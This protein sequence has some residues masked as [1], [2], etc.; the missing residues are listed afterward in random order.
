MIGISERGI[1]SC[2]GQVHLKA[3]AALLLFLGGIALAVSA[4]EPGK[5]APIRLPIPTPSLTDVPLTLTIVLKRTDQKDFDGFLRSIQTP[6]SPAY[7]QYLSPEE[8]A[9]RF[10]PSVR[11]YGDV[12]QWLRGE[13]FTV[14]EGSANRLTLTATGTRAQAERALQIHL[15]DHKIGGQTFYANDREPT[16][17]GEIAHRVQ[18]VIGL[19]NQARP[20]PVYADELVFGGCLYYAGD[21]AY[22]DPRYHNCDHNCDRLYFKLR[23]RYLR[24]CLLSKGLFPNRGGNGPGGGNPSSSSTSSGL[25][26][27]VDQAPAPAWLGAD[28]TGQTIGLLEFDSFNFNDISDYLAYVG[29]PPTEIDRLSQVHI[30]GGAV[31]GPDEAEVLLDIVAVMTN[32]RGA[33]VVVYDA[34]FAG[35]RASFQTLFNKMITDGVSVISNSWVYC[36]D[37]A[38]LADVQSIDSVLGSAAAAGITVLNSTGDFGSTCVNGSANTIS[39]PADSPNATAVGGTSLSEG[40]GST[41][42]SEIFWNGQRRTPPSGPGG[43]GVSRFFNRPG[44]QNGFSTSPMR[45]IPDVALNADP[46]NGTEICQADAGGCPTGAQ[47]G[48]TSLAAPL[49]AAFVAILN[50]AQGQN[51]G[52]LNPLLYPLGNTN[53]FHSAASMGSDFA[54]VGLG[55]PNLNLIHR[56]LAGKIPGPVSASVSE[57]VANPNGALADGSAQAFVV[58]RLRDADG[59]TVSGKTVTLA[60]N[61][62][63][64]A[65][66]TPGS[67]ISNVAN[68]AV[69]FSV[70]DTTPEIVTFTATDMTDGVALQ[71]QVDVAFVALPAAAGGITA[72]PNTV[73]ADGSTTTTITVTLQDAKGGPA[74]D[75]VVNLSQGDGGSVISTTTATTDAMGK[76]QFTAVSSKAETVTYT[77]VDVTDQ[78]LP[79]PGNAMV[80]FV[81]PSG[82]CSGRNSF[83]FGTAAPGYAVTTF[84]GNFPIDCFSGLGPIGIAFSP[85]NNLLVIDTNNSTLYSFG[86]KGGTASPV[87]SLGFVIPSNGRLAGLTFGRDGRLYATGGGGVFELD[88]ATGAVVRTV[89][90]LNADG[91]GLAVDPISGD[92]FVA[93]PFDG[94]KRILNYSSNTA[95]LVP[96]ASGDF[97]GF[98]F[99]VDGTIYGASGGGAVAR[100]TGTNA[101]TPGVVTILTFLNSP[102]GIG[103]EPNPADASKPFLYVNRNDGIITRIDTSKLPATPPN[104]CGSPCT[105]I[106]TGGSRG[107]FVTVGN[108]RCLYA[109]QSERVIK[110]T[111]ADGTC[112]FAPVSQE[113]RLILTPLTINPPPAQG[114]AVT[115]VASLENVTGAADVPVTLFASGANAL[116]RFVRSD[117][118]GKATFTYTGKFAGADEVSAV[119][120]MGSSQLFSNTANVTWTSGK[121][122]TFLTLNQSLGTGAPNKSIKL[123]ANLVDVSSSPPAP[124]PNATV[125]LHLAGQSC[126]GVT[127]ANGNVV[128]SVTPTVAAGR[129]DLTADFAGTSQFLASSNKKGFDLIAALPH[130]LLNI[131]TRMRV[132]TGDKAL[133]GG[134]IIT[135][136]ESKKV[137]IRGIGPSLSGFGL[138]D[139]LNDPI[140]ELHP[141]N[142]PT[143]TNDN[144]KDSQRA[145]IEASGLAPGDER[146]SAIIATLPP[147]NH[148]AILTG[149]GGSIG[150]GLVEV[151]DLSQP[152][153]ARLANISSRGF[154]DTGDNIMIAGFIAG[155]GTGTLVQV[156]VRGIGPSLTTAGVPDALQDPMLELHDGNGATLAMNDDWKETQ[157]ADIE[158]TQIPPA[159]NRESAILSPLAPGNYTAILRGKNNATGNALVEVYNLP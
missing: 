135:G 105:D 6:G 60:G 48:G 131:S 7:R 153:D 134:F 142:G 147:G 22:H 50:Q 36:E 46:A 120:D 56:A 82:F 17:P 55:S 67:G 30:N 129:Y 42:L 109:T 39:V 38:S 41:Y 49:W 140:L 103:V 43:F 58:V 146:E 104:P 31:L 77:A 123:K 85:D 141:A 21:A 95:T 14:I 54:H 101:V 3:G 86:Q 89:V 45:S 130:Q 37:Q 138:Q 1:R 79:V 87:T 47:Y 127:D 72:S 26:S 126:S 132:L 136:S 10:G 28:G 69:V 137:I 119:A 57:V 157:Q 143:V 20:A 29:L 112:G 152:A 8:Q 80:T 27:L 61:S 71:T 13:G 154:V 59:H 53:A 19:S 81:N 93:L 125:N 106:Y 90:P 110:I 151:Y 107:D 65:T 68:G 16:L 148:T 100:V 2:L 133:I 32:A 78:N 92:L 139:V 84:A 114:T 94:I 115:F 156:L 102:D 70:K 12:E 150:G 158:Q 98:T 4:F 33:K 44:Y 9:A 25:P 18:A 111:N 128:C 122:S 24:E 145:E 124:I 64:H 121:H 113:P 23:S 116:T 75:K 74:P 97:D 149:K 66:I 88:P 108:D 83:N 159:D 15:G 76:A 118:N 96:Y 5:P 63:S 51:L 11:V 34:P 35:I 91:K 99:D 40:P 62:G 144:W 73:N 155:P 117:A 52:A